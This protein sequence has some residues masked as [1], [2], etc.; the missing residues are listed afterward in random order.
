MSTQEAF[1]IKEILV[2]QLKED[3]FKSFI[4]TLENT[5]GAITEFNEAM[6]SNMVESMT[7]HRKDGIN[8]FMAIR[9][10]LDGNSDIIFT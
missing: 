5:D 8:A 6:W 7:V 3:Q 2:V 9:E 1:D 10:A 4:E